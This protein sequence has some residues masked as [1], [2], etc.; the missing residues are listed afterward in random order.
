M[1]AISN[2]KALT[3][4]NCF[5]K[6]DTVQYTYEKLIL[7][8]RFRG[9]ITLVVDAETR[10]PIC[11]GCGLCA[12]VCP[13]RLIKVESTKIDKT[14]IIQKWQINLGGCM[15]CGLCVETCPFGGIVMTKN[16]ELA[17]YERANFVYSKERLLETAII[18]HNEAKT[19]KKAEQTGGKP[20]GE[21]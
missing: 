8:D 20:E 13:D 5:S 17:D 3:K 12:K 18:K 14:R 4:K 6:S 9:Q 11:T 15:F 16:Y 2:E 10:E 1:K 19:P 21:D 7:K